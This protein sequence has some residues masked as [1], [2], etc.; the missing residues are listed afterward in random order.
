MLPSELLLAWEKIR[1]CATFGWGF[2]EYNRQDVREV[3]EASLIM[4]KAHNFGVP[5]RFR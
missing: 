2:D 5:I 4:E 1:F 3:A